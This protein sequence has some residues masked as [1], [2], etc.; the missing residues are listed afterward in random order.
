MIPSEPAFWGLGR[1]KSAA[2]AEVC[3][4][5]L[6]WERP[7]EGD[8]VGP[9]DGAEAFYSVER[10]ESTESESGGGSSVRGTAPAIGVEVNRS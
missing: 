10:A 9:L 4:G 8:L 1:L 3:R 5:V 7:P 6:A 2:V